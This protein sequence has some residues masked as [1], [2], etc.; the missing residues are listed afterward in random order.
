MTDIIEDA[1]PSK[2]PRVEQPPAKGPTYMNVVEIDG[3][4]CTH[5]VSWPPG[6]FFTRLI[7]FLEAAAPSRIISPLLNLLRKSFFAPR[8]MTTFFLT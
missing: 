3:K 2:R 6:M 4:S 8:F 5:E 7:C 1:Q